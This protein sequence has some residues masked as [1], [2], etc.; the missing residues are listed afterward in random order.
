[1]AERTKKPTKN[2][3]TKSLEDVVKTIPVHEDSTIIPSGS[4]MYN[5]CSTNNSFGAFKKGKIANIIGNSHAGKTIL[6]LTTLAMCAHIPQYDE[7]KLVYDDIEEADE[8]DHEYMFGKKYVKRVGPPKYTKK[9]DPDSSENIEDWQ[10][11]LHTLLDNKEPFIY[12][13]DSFDA[14]HS[15][16]DETKAQEQYEARKK[17]NKFKGTMGMAKAK[18]AS[19]ALRRI[20]K[21]LKVSN[22]ILII[23]SQARD[24]VNPMSPA[25]QT[26]S[27]GRALKFYSTHEIWGLVTGKLS[28]TV[29]G[30]KF[31]IGAY[32][33]WKF[34]KN[35]LTGR[36]REANFPIYSDIGIDDITSC[37]DY[38]AAEKLIK[39]AEKGS[40]ITI[41]DLKITGTKEKVIQTIEENDLEYKISKMCADRW[42]EVENQLRLKGRKRRFK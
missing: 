1:M 28:K 37:L 32:T 17:G 8:F 4:T 39:K 27:G 22:S 15:M 3:R 35:K 36:N 40:K 31:E 9:G 14:L 6:A 23:V 5:L 34:T 20:R 38:L 33:R 30:H 25:S 19:F 26:R 2:K 7:Y 41:P 13:T 21:R 29:D 11:N 18:S 12:V 42:L 16:E 24:N 10:D